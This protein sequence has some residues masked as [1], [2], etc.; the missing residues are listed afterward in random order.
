MTA[1]SESEAHRRLGRP[2]RSESE[3]FCRDLASVMREFDDKHVMLMRSIPQ[4][5][6]EARVQHR[7]GLC[8]FPAV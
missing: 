8:Y 1:L 5:V 3:Q 6:A 2:K 4:M 7:P